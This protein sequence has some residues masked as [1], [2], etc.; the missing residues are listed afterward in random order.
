M[1][2]RRFACSFDVPIA[3]ASLRPHP[4]PPP[5]ANALKKRK[6]RLLSVRN[7][8]AEK[9]KN[10]AL[11][12]PRKARGKFDERQRDG[13]SPWNVSPNQFPPRIGPAASPPGRCGGMDVGFSKTASRHRLPLSF[14]G[15]AWERTVFEAPPP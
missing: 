14:L 5:T 3:L 4:F 9:K 7:P 8:L 1:T 11:D 15:S 13:R 10:E 12:S 6:K 2:E